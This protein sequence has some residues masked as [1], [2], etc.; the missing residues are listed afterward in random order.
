MN[1][2]SENEQNML[3]MLS[4]KSVTKKERDTLEVVKLIQMATNAT[5][6]LFE[7]SD[8]FKFKIR[9]EQN[10][11]LQKLTTNKKKNI[12]IGNPFRDL[13]DT[14]LNSQKSNK[15]P[16]QVQQQLDMIQQMQPNN[17]KAIFDYIDK[18]N[19]TYEAQKNKLNQ[20]E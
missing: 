12:K 17:D 16:E 19:S 15:F 18:M 2:Q 3:E 10:S 5:N 4:S 1:S 20:N 11:A 13:A 7:N 14:S 9:S 8:N 6:N